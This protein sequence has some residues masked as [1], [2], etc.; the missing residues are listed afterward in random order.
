MLLSA[1]Q[2]IMRTCPSLAMEEGG[3]AIPTALTTRDQPFLC[4]PSVFLPL[5]SYS[6]WLGKPI[7]SGYFPPNL[8][9]PFFLLSTNLVG[10]G[11]LD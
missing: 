9:F 2:L 6:T 7:K 8:G 11:P 4:L 10:S 5:S 1:P 3:L